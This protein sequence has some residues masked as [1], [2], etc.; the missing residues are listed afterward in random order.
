MRTTI[1]IVFCRCTST[2]PQWR[3]VVRPQAALRATQIHRSR[4]SICEQHRH[5]VERHTSGIRPWLSRREPPPRVAG[6]RRPAVCAGPERRCRGRRML[7]GDRG[8]ARQIR[9]PPVSP[10]EAPSA[11]ARCGRPERPGAGLLSAGTP[12]RGRPP[13]WPGEPCRGSAA[14]VSVLRLA[15]PSCSPR[16]DVCCASS[17]RMMWD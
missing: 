4:S 1:V 9:T 15:S 6:C 11:V 7:E 16:C 17:A 12:L 14:M 5:C 13:G 8:A 2:G 10:G 3:A